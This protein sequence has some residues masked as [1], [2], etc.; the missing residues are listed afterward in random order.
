MKPHITARN[1]NYH[2]NPTAF[3][4]PNFGAD[5]RRHARTQLNAKFG[6][7]A[8]Q[9]FPLKLPFSMQRP[10]QQIMFKS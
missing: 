4:D 2:L 6:A 3:K 9:G 10:G 5:C 8:L 1:W 7:G